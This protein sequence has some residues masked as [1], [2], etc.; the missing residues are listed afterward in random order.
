MG[1]GLAGAAGVVGSGGRCRGG[2]RGFGIGGISYFVMSILVRAHVFL[3][4]VVEGTGGLGCL[5]YWRIRICGRGDWKGLELSMLS[6]AGSVAS[7]VLSLSTVV[8]VSFWRECLDISA[9][10]YLVRVSLGLGMQ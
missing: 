10:P 5:A 4:V 6:S 9:Q 1:R 2:G 8:A 7:Q 3:V